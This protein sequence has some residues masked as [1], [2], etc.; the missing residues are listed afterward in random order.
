MSLG[1]LDR[2]A[3]R[4]PSYPSHLTPVHESPSSRMSTP[5]R[6]MSKSTG[7]LGPGRAAPETP[8]GPPSGRLDR[9]V[10]VSS[11]VL[12]PV[13]KPTRAQL[14]RQ[15]MRDAQNSSKGEIEFHI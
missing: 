7:H 8:K 6:T 15:K 3:R 9:R 10:S 13:G 2:L 4:R 14:L 5:A 12:G 1:R 11:A